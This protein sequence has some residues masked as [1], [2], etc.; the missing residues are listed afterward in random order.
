MASFHGESVHPVFLAVYERGLRE[1]EAHRRE[2]SHRLAQRRVVDDVGH[3]DGRRL[4]GVHGEV[5]HV[6]RLHTL[7][8]RRR[9]F[10]DAVGAHARHISRV[11]HHDLQS[12][13]LEQILGVAERLVA[14]VRYLHHFAMM[15]VYIKSELHSKT[16]CKHH[17]NHCGDIP[18]EVTA[19]ELAEKLRCIHTLYVYINMYKDTTIVAI[20]KIYAKKSANLLIYFVISHEITKSVKH[21][22][23]YI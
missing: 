17:R 15:G 14:H 19:L 22:D 18:P 8:R 9:L 11:A 12:T 13:L 2:L 6:T 10:E 5:Y 1:L 21:Y 4:R 3:G 7:A 20:H 23:R 16:H